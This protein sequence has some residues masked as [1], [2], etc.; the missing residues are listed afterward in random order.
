SAPPRSAL[1]RDRSGPT[2]YSGVAEPQSTSL[3]HASQSPHKQNLTAPIAN[4]SDKSAGEGAAAAR[5]DALHVTMVDGSFEPMRLRSV[6]SNRRG[7][8][9]PRPRRRPQTGG[10]TAPP[11]A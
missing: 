11:R 3:S 6:T 4:R 10:A 8:R 5:D 7:P 9:A 1:D 2:F